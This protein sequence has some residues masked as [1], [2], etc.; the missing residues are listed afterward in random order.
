MTDEGA[1]GAPTCLSCLHM[2]ICVC[3][4]NVLLPC[5]GGHD[6]SRHNGL[7]MCVGSFAAVGSNDVYSIISDH[8]DK[9]N[10]V[11]LRNIR[12]VN[13][14]NSFVESDHL[15][16]DVDMVEVIRALLRERK[17]RMGKGEMGGR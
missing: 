11:H 10:Y 15:D 6:A 9:I 16:G 12:R 1:V 7:T 4:Y 17:K 5:P 2:Y 13:D 8:A 14:D 3:V